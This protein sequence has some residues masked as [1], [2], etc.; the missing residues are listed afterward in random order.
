MPLAAQRQV[1]AQP[2]HPNN[3]GYGSGNDGNTALATWLSICD[4]NGFP[5]KQT[6]SKQQS[7]C[8]WHKIMPSRRRKV[9]TFWCAGRISA[10]HRHG[11][12][13]QQPL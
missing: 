8:L 6:G 9:D 2:G 11:K 3:G 13:R 4:G 5:A 7:T 12:H 1:T 10:N